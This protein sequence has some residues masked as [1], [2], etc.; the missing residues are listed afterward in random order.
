MHD[1][2]RLLQQSL[3]GALWSMWTY[4]VY[5]SCSFFTKST[6]IDPIFFFFNHV[7]GHSPMTWHWFDAYIRAAAWAVFTLLSINLECYILD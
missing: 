4:F 5:L 6:I 1:K 2:V 3:Y 7:D